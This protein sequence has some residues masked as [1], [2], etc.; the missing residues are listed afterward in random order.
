LS[1]ID[2]A[3]GTTPQILNRSRGTIQS[4]TVHISTLSMSTRIRVL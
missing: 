2:I 4:S 1:S 3:V